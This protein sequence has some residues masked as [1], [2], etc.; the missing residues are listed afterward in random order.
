MDDWRAHLRDRRVVASISGGKD[1]AA[2]G[3]WLMEQGIDYDRVFADTGWEHPKTYEYLRGPLTAKLGPI[4]EV[5]GPW[6]ME[7]LIRHK[8]M[9]PSR[10]AKFCTQELK[11]NP[12]KRYLRGRDDDHVNAVAIRAEESAE[13][14]HALE[15]EWSPDLDCEVWRPMLHWTLDEIKE[16]HRRHGL[17]PNPLYLMGAT[18]VGCWPCISARKKEIA[19]IAREDPGRIDT[20]RALETELEQAWLGRI[21]ARGEE[22][23]KEP[24]RYFTLRPDGKTHVRSPIDSVVA[25]A[26]SDN[27]EP[28]AMFDEGCMRWGLCER[29]E[30]GAGDE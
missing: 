5:R 17:A 11:F 9:F 10:V 16:I 22:K 6:A 4:T 18:R 15:W 28:P 1:S 30:P 27:P 29:P 19:L 7:Q 14:A 23:E 2:M 12:I 3:L 20:I 13:R 21:A 26:Q 24:P 8:G 25:W